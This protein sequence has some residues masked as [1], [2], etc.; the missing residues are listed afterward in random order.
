M[1]NT[2][3]NSQLAELM[4]DVMPKV[5]QSIRV[6]M[7]HGRGD[8]LTVPQ[9]RV[10]AAIKRG[11]N[12]NKD[13]SEHLGVSEAAISRMLEYLVKNDLVQKEVSKL[14]RRQSVLSLS[15]EGEKLQSSIKAEA[16]NNLKNK[17]EV[18]SVLEIESVINGLKILR[19]NLSLLE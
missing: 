16:R 1:S 3:N 11:I 5:M 14:D 2:K 19:D 7:R 13:L 4:M 10:L 8:R 6:K 12:H 15:N 18:L 17:L 9:F